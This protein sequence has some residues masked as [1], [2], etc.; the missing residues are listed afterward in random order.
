[1]RGSRL[2]REI[3]PRMTATAFLAQQGRH[4][5]ELRRQNHIGKR[6]HAIGRALQALQFMQGLN[7]PVSM[8]QHTDM[9]RHQMAQ[10]L[11]GRCQQSGIAIR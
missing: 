2:G 10:I 8:A 6:C 5:D 1:M 4:G 9:T 3:A 7:Q 11:H